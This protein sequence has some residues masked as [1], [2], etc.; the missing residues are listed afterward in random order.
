MFRIALGPI[1]RSLWRPKGMSQDSNGLLFLL[2][3]DFDDAF[4]LQ[5]QLIGEGLRNPIFALRDLS[6]AKQHLVQ[7]ASEKAWVHNPSPHVAILSLRSGPSALDFLGWL[8]D[9][10]KLARIVVVVLSDPARP[11]ELQKALDAG[12]STFHHW[13]RGPESLARTIR[14]LTLYQAHEIELAED[15]EVV[16]SF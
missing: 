14:S 16:A 1:G 7:L 11:Q 10:P 4:R 12:A 5:S 15:P 3:E 2:G 9:H 8:R 6:L 13:D